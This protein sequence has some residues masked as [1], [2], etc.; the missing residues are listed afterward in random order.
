[1]IKSLFRINF[2]LAISFFSALSQDSNKEEK[3]LFDMSLEELMEVEIYSASKKA[4]SIFDSPLSSTVITS[5]E[6]LQSGVTSIPEALRLV[7]GVI[8][9]EQ[10]NGTYDIHIRGMDNVPPNG[11]FTDTQNQLTLVM[12]DNRIV[13]NYLNGGTFWETLPIDLNDVDKIEVIRGPSSALYGPNAVTGVINIITRN[14]QEDGVYSVANAQVGTLKTTVANASVGYMKNKWSFLVSGNYQKRDRYE[15]DY[16]IFDRGQYM[17]LP[18]TVTSLAIPRPN[19]EFTSRFP[20]P[21]LSMEKYGVNA[22]LNYNDDDLAIS[23]R[24]GHQDSRAQR[25]FSSLADTPFNT[26]DVYSSYVDLTAGYKGFNFKI[27]NTFGEQTSYSSAG[28]PYNILATSLEYSF[29]KGGLTLRPGIS[30]N[31]ADYEWESIKEG[32]Y[33]EN[34]ALSLRADYKMGDL[35]LIAALRGD[36]YS[37]PDDIY[38]S[39]QLGG[40]Y[41]I[42]EDNMVRIIYSRANTAPFLFNLYADIDVPIPPI[43]QGIAVEGNPNIKL[44]TMDMVEIGYR[45]KLTDNMSL[46]FEVFTSTIR[47]FT[48]VF[49]HRTETRNHPTFGPLEYEVRRAQNIEAEAKQYGATASLNLVPVKNLNLRLFATYQQTDTYNFAPDVDDQNTLIDLEHESTPSVFGGFFMN[50]RPVSKLNINL[51]SYYMAE[52]ILDHE[53]YI[54]NMMGQT[55][56]YVLNDDIPSNFIFN[57]KVSYEVTENLLVFVNARNIGASK[58]QFG[59]TDRI[60]A[61]YLAG[62]NFS[63]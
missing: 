50:Y 35:R 31:R 52:H 43:G 32:S 27:S 37:D 33:I 39:W 62:L 63:L 45:S 56:E 13:Y 34:G 24:A 10:T 44:T 26:N 1:M 42:N 30:Y 28:I 49:Y 17:E 9:R 19:F 8:V 16:Y 15:E 46:D 11:Q 47:D 57:T 38:A 22:A 6:I 25:V 41:N 55:R 59:F 23:L 40:T 3:D 53:D 29:V 61:L 36:K 4:E 48:R 60:S 18:D 5:K 54:I 7:P 20:E 21:A 2:L 51:S 12:I 14:P 58:K